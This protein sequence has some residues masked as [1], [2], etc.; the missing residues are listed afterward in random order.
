MLSG[1]T[2]DISEPIIKEHFERLC[3]QYNLV[4]PT[5]ITL[6]KPLNLAY[7]VFVNEK[8]AQIVFEVKFIPC[9]HSTR[10]QSLTYDLAHPGK[11]ELP[12]F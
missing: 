11:R 4:G 2:R 6:L 12:E 1:L 3:S 5:A 9:F 7:V 10:T 8:I